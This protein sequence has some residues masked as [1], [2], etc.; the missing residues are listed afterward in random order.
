MEPEPTASSPLGAVSPKAGLC[1]YAQATRSMPRLVGRAARADSPKADGPEGPCLWGGRTSRAPFF[2]CVPTLGP[3]AHV[4]RV[5]ARRE[6]RTPYRPSLACAT[7]QRT[8]W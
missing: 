8:I 1:E 7:S 2:E 3:R 6:G 5:P 4:G